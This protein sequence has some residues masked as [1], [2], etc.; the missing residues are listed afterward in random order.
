[1]PLELA[2]RLA[3]WLRTRQKAGAGRV[4]DSVHFVSGS[5][6]DGFAALVFYLLGWEEAAQQ[7]L[8]VSLK[9]GLDSEFDSL[10]HALILRLLP[11]ADWSPLRNRPLY[12]G[13]QIVSKNW[14]LFRALS[15]ELYGKRGC[16]EA[17]QSQQPSGLFPDSPSGQ[18]TPTCYHAKICSVLALHTALLESREHSQRL[19]KGLDALLC[20]IGPNGYIVPYGRSRNTLFAYASAYLGLRLGARLF[21]EGRYSWGAARVLQR[22]RSFVAEDGHIPA[23]LNTGEWMRQDWDVYINNPDYNAYAAAC[24]LIAQRLAP[25]VPAE[26]SPATATCQ[27]GPLLVARGSGHYFSCSLAGESAPY[28]SPFFCDLRYAGM[29]P[30]LYEI[31]GQSTVFHGDYCWDG[32]DQTRRSLVDPELSPWIPYVERRDGRYWVQNYDSVEVDV[33]PDR[34]IV[35]GRGTPT[36]SF[37]RRNWQRFLESRIQRRPALQMDRRAL[38]R[39]LEVT[40]RVDF[41]SAGVQ[42]TAVAPGGGVLVNRTRLEEKLCPN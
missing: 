39:S 32:R 29:V 22:M 15:R 19:E 4:L 26:V 38:A 31:E 1:M 25:E 18:A 6:A 16:F 14:A 11:D 34:L 3:H 8:R 9:R 20:L 40:M 30:L 28:G 42:L 35:H 12:E 7:A 10:A 2:S 23:C 13:D 41:Q 27:L 24:L 5:Y 37:P 17:L 21:Q 33:Q 36:A